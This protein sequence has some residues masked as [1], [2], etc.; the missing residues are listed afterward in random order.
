M[1]RLFAILADRFLFSFLHLGLRAVLGAVS[2]F[3]A[4]I[5]ALLATVDCITS[6]IESVKDGISGLWPALTVTRTRRLLGKPVRHRIGFT[7]VALEV[8]VRES[9]EQL[10]FNTDEP[11]AYAFIDETLLNVPEGGSA[12]KCLDI[13]LESLL[14]I[15]NVPLLGS[16]FELVPG[17][18]R[19]Y[20]GDM[21]PADLPGLVTGRLDVAY[22]S[23]LA[24]D[25]P[26]EDCYIPSSPQ[27]LQVMAGLSGQSLAI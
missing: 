23:L 2:P 20:I 3:I 7:S 4:I 6:I 12:V 9:T 26:F 15:V 25:S 5:A 11:Q 21:I 1:A 27:F 22:C 13:F 14:D 17:I 18:L 8:H 24:K 16:L 10:P 19:R